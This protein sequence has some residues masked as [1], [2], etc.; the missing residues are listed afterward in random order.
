M[1]YEDFKKLLNSI[2]QHNTPHQVNSGNKII[3]AT[4]RFVLLLQ[5]LAI[6]ENFKSLSFQF[7]IS[8]KRNILGCIYQ[9]VVSDL[10]QNIRSSR[11]EVF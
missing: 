1:K 3:T 11:P 8:G 6:G 2:E 7:R 9:D 4:E 10:S 5:F